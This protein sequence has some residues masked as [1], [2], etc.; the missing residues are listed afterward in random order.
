MKTIQKLEIYA[1]LA[2]LITSLIYIYISILPNI[3]L[4]NEEQTATEL[5]SKIFLLI[6]FPALLTAI[7]SYTPSVKQ[8]KIGFVALLFGTSFL[9]LFFGLFFMLAELVEPQALPLATYM[10]LT[11]REI[12]FL[13]SELQVE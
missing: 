8:S 3:D 12:I 2:T 10:L 6:I 9:M 4:R 5:F 13:L 1:G 7:G 11:I